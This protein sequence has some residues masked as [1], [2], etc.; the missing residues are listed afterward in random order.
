MENLK[1]SQVGAYQTMLMHIEEFYERGGFVSP[2]ETVNNLIYNTIVLDRVAK[3]DD[4]SDHAP[5]KDVED[6]VYCA[7]KLLAFV[8]NVMDVYVKLKNK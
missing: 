7:H 4:L 5:I 1:K 3:G 2:V 8:A 6:T